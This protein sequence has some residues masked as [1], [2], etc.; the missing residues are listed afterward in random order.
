MNISRFFVDRPIFATVL[1]IVITLLGGLAYFGLPVSQYPEVIPPTVVVTATYP[2]ASSQT[3]AD[4]V[5]A[6]LE[7]EIN[8][9]ENMLYLSTSST[10]DGRMTMTVTFKLGTNLDQAQVL[11]QN[12][13]S[14]ALPRLPE[15]VRRLGV[16]AQKRSPDLTLAIQFFSPDDSRDVIYLSNYVTLQIQN[17]IA[18]LP[19]VAEASSLGLEMP[20]TYS[21][22]MIFYL[23]KPLRSGSIASLLALRNFSSK[24]SGHAA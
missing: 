8:G 19:G 23:L 13:V 5:A 17:Q 21:V 3:L 16:T 2:G 22:G 18:R 20:E 15:E 4:T 12:R 14:A 7:Q 11:V 6:P 24:P 10:N 9:V 1:S